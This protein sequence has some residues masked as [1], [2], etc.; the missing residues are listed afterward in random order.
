MLEVGLLLGAAE[1]R[2]A[3]GLGLVV[4]VVGRGEGAGALGLELGDALGLGLFVRGG[5]GVGLGLGL[6]GLLGLL[7][8]YVGVFGGVPRVEDLDR[9]MSARC[10]R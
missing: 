2:P 1:A 7:A 8:L 4:K 3:L 9:T 6:G 10:L 5:F